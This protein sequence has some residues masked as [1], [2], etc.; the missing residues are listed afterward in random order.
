M[1]KLESRIKDLEDDAARRIDQIHLLEDKLESFEDMKDTFVDALQAKLTR[2]E[3]TAEMK[4]SE[5]FNT[6]TQVVANAQAKFSEMENNMKIL[7]QGTKDKFEDMEKAIK[8]G[9]GGFKDTRRVG[10]LPNKMMVPKVFLDDISVWKKWK[11]DVTKYFDEEREGMKHV[12]DT[13]AQQKE[14]I[15]ASIL[16]REFQGNPNVIGVHLK[17]WK[18]FVSRVREVDGRRG[19]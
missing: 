10:F 2:M 7:Y 9:T 11:D 6:L 1:E 19:C 18:H 16:E 12:M 8:E 4:H 3:T 15:T 14:T 17:E 5:Q 13:M